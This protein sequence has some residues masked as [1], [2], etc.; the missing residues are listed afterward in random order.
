[1]TYLSHLWPC[2]Y[3]Q[4]PPIIIP[5]VVGYPCHLVLCGGAEVGQTHHTSVTSAPR[6]LSLSNLHELPSFKVLDKPRTEVTSISP[7]HKKPD[8]DLLE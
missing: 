8:P 3:K 6:A 2:M 7:R 4:Y 1:M 5:R